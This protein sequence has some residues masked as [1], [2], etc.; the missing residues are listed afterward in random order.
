MQG[1]VI[2]P[3]GIVGTETV[4]FSFGAAS[5][6]A[7]QCYSGVTHGSGYDAETRRY[8][9]RNSSTGYA[10]N[11][12]ANHVESYVNG[13]TGKIFAGK[14]NSGNGK[15]AIALCTDTS[16]AGYLAANANYTLTAVTYTWTVGKKAV[17]SYT[18]VL[19]NASDTTED[20]TS[21][22]A[23]TYDAAAHYMKAT[24]NTVEY[25]S[26]TSTDGKAPSGVSIIIGGS[27]KAL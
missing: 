3:S 1:Y 8:S 11:S 20:S 21:P 15:F 13:T 9:S 2:T 4:S 7:Y 12:E 25:A 16:N 17:S 19:T 6:N 14:T 27:G 10:F 18:W 5:G 23:V 22:F 24:V 26:M